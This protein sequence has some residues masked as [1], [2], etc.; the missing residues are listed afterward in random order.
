[1]RLHFRLSPNT[2][3]VPFDYQHYLTGVFHKWMGWNNLHDSISLYSLSWLAGGRACR[4]GL[5]FPDGARWFVS[6]WDESIIKQLVA[7]ALKDPE[8]CCNMGVLEIQMQ[9]TPQFGGVECFT[10]ASPVFI[11]KYDDNHKAQHLTFKDND[12]DVYL[13]ETLKKKL[14]TAGINEDASVKFD[15]NYTNAKTK[16]VRING[17]ENRTSICPVIVEGSP[18]AVQFAW[19]VGIGHS[20]GSGF[21]AIN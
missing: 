1:M 18:L 6:A 3:T 14:H 13:T 4:E 8:V 19:N 10:A 17:I 12:A 16:L 15:K 5:N 2:K 11:R 20:T 7:G 9:E 21:G